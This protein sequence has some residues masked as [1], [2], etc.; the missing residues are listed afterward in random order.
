M[1]DKLQPWT[2]FFMI[3]LNG[4]IIPLKKHFQRSWKVNTK[5]IKRAG[6][7]KGGGCMVPCLPLVHEPWMSF[8]EF[9]KTNTCIG[10][11]VF[12][13]MSPLQPI[14]SVFPAKGML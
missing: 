5:E 6:E 9:N 2:I 4:N 8:Y 13:T 7:G 12:F 1:P 10:K 14:W 11:T 3:F